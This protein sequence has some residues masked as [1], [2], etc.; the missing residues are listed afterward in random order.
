MTDEKLIN[1]FL[2]RYYKVIIDDVYFKIIDKETEKKYTFKT[3]SREINNLSD[4]TI[5][6]KKI[7]GV[8][9]TNDETS[10]EIL[11]RWVRIHQDKLIKEL[12]DYVKSINIK[13]GSTSLL[14]KTINRFAHGKDSGLYSTN[15]ITE[16][17]T[18]YYN[19]N[20]MLPFLGK[21]TKDFNPKLGSVELIKQI[22]DRLET[23]T[24]NV[25][26]FALDYLNKWYCE[27]V[28][29][30][31]MRDFLTQL[32]ITLGSRNWVVTWIGHGPISKDKILSFFKDEENIHYDFIMKAYDDWYEMAVIQASEREMNRNNY[33][34]TF[35]GVNLQSNF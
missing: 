15:F 19:E 25:Y 16:Y 2:D 12:S 26:Q 1:N 30:D 20:Y 14:F 32:V 23:E 5:L 33:G 10:L 35:P 21:L 28:I 4:F 18:E 17:I 13:E 7:F 8:F 31:K 11:S 27:N 34:S 24:T 22:S 29:G 3:R 9:T 6:F